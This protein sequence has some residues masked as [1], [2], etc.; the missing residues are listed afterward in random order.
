MRI[1][2]MNNS[3]QLFNILRDSQRLSQLEGDARMR[4]C[5]PLLHSVTV[6]FKTR[7]Q[8]HLSLDT[9]VLD[10]VMT[11]LSH[12][13]FKLRWII[14][15][16]DINELPKLPSNQNELVKQLQEQFALAAK[17]VIVIIIILESAVQGWERV[18][19]LYQS[20]DPNPTQPTHGRKKK[21][22]Q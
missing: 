14:L 21:I 1:E 2:L 12:N 4:H 3:H 15:V 17:F 19:T 5:M 22:K 18:W 20:K 10:A 6:G 13:F 8:K 9:A 7:F 11:S 16:K